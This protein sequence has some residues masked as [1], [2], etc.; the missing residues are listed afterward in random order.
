MAAYGRLAGA[1]V[2]GRLQYR[3]SFGLDF[4]TSMLAALLDFLA[5]LVVFQHL[6]LLGGWSLWEVAFLYG[7]AGVSFGLADLLVGQLD[8]LGQ[9]IRMG[10]FDVVLVRPLGT[11]FQVVSSEL[12]LRRL[13]KVLQAG[14]VLALTLP[15]LQVAWSPAKALVLLLMLAAGMAIFVGIWI[16]GAAISF[17]TTDVSEVVNSVTYGGNF[18]TAYPVN[19]FGAWVRRFL[20]FGV[21]LAFVAYYPS[22][23]ILD[24]RDALGGPAWLSFASP[25]VAAAVLAAGAAVW[26]TGVRHYRSTGS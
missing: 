6:P 10:T 8:V 2:R 22:L 1:S 14:T 7:T 23:F 12:A 21:P 24:R 15:H 20:A 9:M 4:L 19:V 17:W 26:R 25:L 3:L 11:L 18:L 13:G 16:A 5:I